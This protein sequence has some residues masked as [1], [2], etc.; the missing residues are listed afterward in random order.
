[1]NLFSELEIKKHMSTNYLGQ[2]IVFYRETGSTN[3]DA[4]ELALK[5]AKEGV[6]IVADRQLSGRGR[7]GRDWISPPG[8]DIYMSL[9][10]RPQC[11]IE[12]ASELTL[13]MAMSVLEAIQEQ[14]PHVNVGI[15][16]PNDI[17]INGKKICGILTEMNIVQQSIDYVVIGIG[18]NVNQ[19]EFHQDIKA[20]ASS[21]MME[22]GQ[23]ADRAKLIANVMK[24]FE[25][26]YEL[27]AKT[28]DLTY[29]I[30]RYNK[31]LVN[32]DKQVKVLE[33]GGEYQGTARG[34]NTKGEL[35]V[36]CKDGS[37]VAVYAGEVSVR[38]IYG[39]V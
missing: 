16:W 34:I 4:K 12:N 22:T 14:L 17:V 37:Q 35:L 27:F 26:N 31:H 18:I 39:Y 36:D 24:S 11:E 15:K 5:G 28:Q 20:H 21:I 8:K 10:L 29:I 32:V 33:P 23:E 9:L 19:T 13:V 25:I 30:S 2:D 7:R 1:M 6:L 38:G 3:Q